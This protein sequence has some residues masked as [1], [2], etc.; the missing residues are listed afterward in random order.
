MPHGFDCCHG[1][2]VCRKAEDKKD[3]ADRGREGG[4]ESTGTCGTAVNPIPVLLTTY[5]RLEYS[6][7]ALEAMCESP[8]LPL[9]ITVWDNG[10]T[11]PG[12]LEWLD[13]IEGRQHRNT[14]RLTVIRNQENQ[15]LAKAMNWF[16]RQHADAP[17]V[18]KVDNDTVLPKDWLKDLLE[19]MERPLFKAELPAQQ[20]KA[21][22][23]VSFGNLQRM[24]LG[25]I[26]PTCLRPNGPTFD[27]WVR[28]NMTT[29]PF[30]DHYLHFN[31]YVLGTG[32]LINMD[33]IRELGLLFE[34]FPYGPETPHRPDI[35]AAPIGRAAIMRPTQTCLISGWTAYT[36]IAH[37]YD[38]WKFAFYSKVHANLLNLKSEHVLSNDYPEYD[39]ELKD[40]R[41]QGNAWWEGVGG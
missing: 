14:T 2:L 26:S 12:A 13:F 16:F 20:V 33:M 9:E 30:K 1:D 17:Y 8:G 22:G 5:N 4:S 15:G 37:D 39:E 27:E 34:H 11:A 3:D 25:A 24:R 19:V 6:K 21:G 38:G 40:A 18:A 32:V 35:M 29:L 36:R 7:K 31:S 23:P 28:D 10:S 41:D